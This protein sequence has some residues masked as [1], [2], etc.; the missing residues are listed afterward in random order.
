MKVERALPFDWFGFMPYPLIRIDGLDEFGVTAPDLFKAL[1]EPIRQRL[2]Q[3]LLAQ[4]LNVTE[5]VEILDQPQSTIS[6]HLKVLRDAELLVDRR[7]GPTTF[8]AAR[9]IRETNGNGHGNGNS[10]LTERV[11]KWLADEPVEPGLAERVREVAAR[12]RGNANFFETIG[13]RWDQLRIQ[14]FGESFH[15]EALTALVPDTWTVADI[16]TGTGYLLPV[17][18]NQFRRVIAVDPAANMLDLARQRPDLSQ[19]KNVDFRPGAFEQLPIADGEL[20]L[21]IASLVLH[22]V[23][24]PGVALREVARAIRTDGKLLLIEQQTHAYEAFHERMG[25]VWHG[26]ESTQIE[27][28]L[29][30]AGF[31]RIKKHA[32]TSFKP[33][34]KNLGEV[35][36]LY[37]MT[38]VRRN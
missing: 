29:T 27:T 33:N 25:D 12:R 37:V 4:E 34:G 18:A 10:H 38:A 9:P 5:L 28:W 32:L 20:D 2:V 11:L 8:Y 15:L 35:P 19:R 24:E 6:R 30:Q 14:A 13:E 17:L 26:F 16:G 22:H 36:G 3:I 31:S 21:A 1:S 23:D 7:S